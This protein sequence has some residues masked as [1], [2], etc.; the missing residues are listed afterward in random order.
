MPAG[1]TPTSDPTKLVP[2]ESPGHGGHDPERR[3]NICMVSDDFLPAATGVGI[4]IQRVA[5]ELVR[6]GHKVCIITSRRPG[7][8]AVSSWEGIT[9]YR[10][11]TV[12]LYGFY[13]AL[14]S[15]STLQRIL[16]ENGVDII[17]CHYLSL[18]LT[19][20]LKAVRGLDV[21]R[22]YTYHMTVDHLTQPLLMKPLRRLLFRAHVRYCNRFDLILAPSAALMASIRGYGVT[23]P[24]RFLTNPVA[25]TGDED[26]H[27]DKSSGF[28][29]LYVGRLNP[30]KNLPYL[31]RGFAELART[32]PDAQLWIVGQ[33]DQAGRLTQ[34]ARELGIASLVRFLGFVPHDTLPQYYGMA[35]V[36]VLP[37]LVETQGLVAMEA[38]RFSKPVIVTRS[39]VSAQEL[40]EDGKNGFIVDPDSVTE[41]ADRLRLLADDAELRRAMGATGRERSRSYSP[42]TVVGQLED[43][44]LDMLA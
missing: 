12:K 41:L 17:H 30:E 16:R 35:D 9:V 43:Y 29:V 7:E 20:T 27:T 34:L 21:R 28:V 19:R 18:L 32:R 3:L 42:A 38:M 5:P 36:F 37:S 2:T 4:H 44:Y 23:T 13:Q 8:P 22:V 24:V 1:I 14:P 26:G 6:R 10:T 15:V 33:G 31:L 39:I 40:V 11:F 25:F